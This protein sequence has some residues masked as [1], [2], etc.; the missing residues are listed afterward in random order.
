MASEAVLQQT[1]VEQSALLVHVVPPASP[2]LLLPEL[3]ELPDDDP[4]EEPLL[5]PSSPVDP[6]LDDEL[7]PE[8]AARAKPRPREATK[9]IFEL[10]MGKTFLLGDEKPGAQPSARLSL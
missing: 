7:Q 2:P 8:P 6:L 9:K 10:C 3:L 4:E 5:P 1:P